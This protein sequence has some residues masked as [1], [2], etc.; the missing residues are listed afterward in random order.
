MVDCVKDPTLQP[1]TWNLWTT[2]KKRVLFACPLCGN[3][4]L[5]DHEIA[6]DGKVTPSVQ[7]MKDGCSFHDMIRLLGWVPQPEERA[8]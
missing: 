7:C 8:D 3:V 1:G 6:A 5:L 4:G 2:G